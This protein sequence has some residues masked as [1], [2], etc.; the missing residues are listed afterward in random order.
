MNTT[1][2]RAFLRQV[3]LCIGTFFR[4]VKHCKLHD[5]LPHDGP[6]PRIVYDTNVWTLILFSKKLPNGTIHEIRVVIDLQ[7]PLLEPQWTQIFEDT[8]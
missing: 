8:V 6:Y 4:N 5:L 3:A 1:S 7:D 2:N